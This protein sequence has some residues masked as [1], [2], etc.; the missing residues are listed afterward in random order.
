MY[1]LS[2]LIGQSW[3]ELQRSPEDTLI[4][5]KIAE[6]RDTEILVG[7][8]T[9]TSQVVVFAR[10]YQ[11]PIIEVARAVKDRLNVSLLEVAALYNRV[12][13]LENI[14]R[15][16]FDRTRNHKSFCRLTVHCREIQQCAVV[17]YGQSL[18]V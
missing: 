7:S 4:G 12:H 18:W 3:R 9:E 13:C 6:Q 17:V 11:M 10:P 16:K 14:R 5:R 2:W 15:F 1:V 8:A